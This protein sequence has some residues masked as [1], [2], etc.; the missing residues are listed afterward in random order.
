[1]DEPSNDSAA[2]SG[3]DQY[4]HNKLERTERQEVLHFCFRHTSK[5]AFRRS[6]II[7]RAAAA[8][9][10]GTAYR[11][12][13]IGCGAGFT[14]LDVAEWLPSRATITAIDTNETMIASARERLS[15]NHPE[16][17][18]N[19]ESNERRQDRVS[20]QVMSGEEAASTFPNQYD[21]VWM[22][23]LVVH[24]PDPVALLRAAAACL[25]PG[26]IMLVEDMN[27]DGFVSDPP[28]YANDLIHRAHI[29]ASLKL[30]ADIR[31]GPK[32]GGYLRQIGMEDISNHAFVPLF[33]KGVAIQPWCDDADDDDFDSDWHCEQGMQLLRMSLES[34]APNFL[35]LETCTKQE[36]DIARESLSE[37]ESADYQLFSV[38]GGQMYQWWGVK[39][40]AKV[41]ADV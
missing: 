28:L 31:R 11:V 33:G 39:P 20:F 22:R 25:K 14:T 9:K 41:N 21:A 35:Q 7:A 23:Y 1:M 2:S 12:L 10:A 27:A 18:S 16:W 4:I 17:T 32:I 6:T 5:G 8:D 34:A 29:A 24:V 37:V 13:E 36:L 26:G 38:P 30:G 3:G 40:N 19:Y 15:T